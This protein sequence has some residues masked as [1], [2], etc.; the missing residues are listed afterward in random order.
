MSKL[1]MKPKSD[2]KDADCITLADYCV[3]AFGIIFIISAFQWVVDG[4]KNFTGPRV[5]EEVF[6]VVEGSAPRP[7]ESAAVTGRKDHGK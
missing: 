7:E 1:P 6:A 2:F 3:A 4:R 5:D